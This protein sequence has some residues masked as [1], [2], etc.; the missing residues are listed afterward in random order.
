MT[1]RMAA[2]ERVA[3][4]SFWP[5]VTRGEKCWEWNGAM[6]GNGY[7]SLKVLYP[8]GWKN[9]S[10]HRA[11]WALHYGTFPD[12]KDVCHHCDNRKCVNPAHLFVGTRSDN[13]KDAAQKGRIYRGGRSWKVKCINGHL[14]SEENTRFVANGWREC[15]IC[16]V[17]RNAARVRPTIPTIAAR[18]EG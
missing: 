1:D 18:V 8:E 14:F 7:G 12:A 4:R 2:L 16:R 6:R 3:D 13:M 15:R 9:I 17:A 5:N 10:A 11:S